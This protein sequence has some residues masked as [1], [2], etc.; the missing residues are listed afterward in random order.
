MCLTQSLI[1]KPH[2][3]SHTSDV[4]EPLNSRFLQ[5]FDLLLH[6]EF[7]GLVVDEARQLSSTVLQFILLHLFHKPF[8]D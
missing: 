6:H 5:L 1:G 4:L 7:K 8:I 2:L 3:F